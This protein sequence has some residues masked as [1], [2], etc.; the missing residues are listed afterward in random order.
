MADL[1]GLI[2]A[3]D[4]AVRNTS[5]DRLCAGLSVRELIEQCERLDQFRRQSQNLYE[6][7]RALFR[8]TRVTLGAI[9][10]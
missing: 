6:R 4:P 9:S 10:L 5:L 2:T 3:S 1:V 8:T 7:V